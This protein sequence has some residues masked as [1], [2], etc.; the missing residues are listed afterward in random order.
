MTRDAIILIGD[1][2]A[3]TSLRLS[4]L[5]RQQRHPVHVVSSGIKALDFIESHSPGLILVAADLCDMRGFEFCRRLKLQKRGRKIPLLLVTRNKEEEAEGFRLGVSD[6]ISEP[7]RTAEVL[8]RVNAYL[9][10]RRPPIGVSTRTVPRD[11]AFPE[12]DDEAWI[13]VAMQAGRMYGFVWNVHTDEIRRTGDCSKILGIAG[14]ATRDTGTSFLRMM[15][16]KDVK[17]FEHILAILSPAFD[18]YSMQYRL[19][20]ADGE[21]VFLRESGRG[22]FDANGQLARVRGLVIDVTE[23]T[24]ALNEL[25]RSQTGILQLI[26]RLPIAVALAGSQGRI[27]YINERFEKVFGYQ[28]EEIAEPDAWWR[29]AY[30]DEK[31]RQDV[32][33]S[34]G[35]AIDAAA[36]HGEYVPPLRYRITDKS[37]KEHSVQVS[38]A[39][40]GNCKL[41]LFDDVTERAR[42]EALLRESEERFRGMAD[43]A[44]VML[45]VSGPDKRCT[46]FNK[47][48][49]T[50]TGRAMEQELGNGWVGG[51]HPEDLDRCLVTYSAAFDARE[52][53]QMEYRLRRADGEYRWILDSGSPRFSPDG[54]FAGYIGS[55]IDITESKRNQERLLVTQKLES[56]GLLAGGVVHDINNFLGCILASTDKSLSEL[57]THSRTRRSLQ[58]I[59]AIAHRALEI[60]QQV[61]IYTGQT[62]QQIERVDIA[63]LVRDMMQLLRV[64]IP[65]EADLNV[66]LP[67]SLFLSRANAP[68]LR[69]VIMNLVINAGEAIGSQNGAIT[70]T[71]RQ[72][73]ALG[74]PHDTGNH[75]VSTGEFIC[76][77]VS[78]TGKGMTDEVRR[79][80]FDPFFTTKVSG[81]GLGLA[82][83]QEIVR[84]HGGNIDVT[85]APG[86][87]TRF[88]IL[89]PC[90]A[91]PIVSPQPPKFLS[92]RVPSRPGS[93]LI[94]EDEETLRISVATMLRKRG[95]SVLEASDGNLAVEAIHERNE[96]IAVV[97]LDLTLPG[98]SS[99]EVFEELRRHRPGVKVILTSAYGLENI[100]GPLKALKSA[101]FIRKPYQFNELVTAVSQVLPAERPVAGKLHQ[102]GTAK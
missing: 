58:Q 1:R 74:Y 32:I 85:S 83:V 97:L 18:S 75:A 89:L 66:N 100:V 34:W 33:A 90:E 84:S 77:E 28:L 48:W 54:T 53:F 76:L 56:V 91:A 87:G 88:Q 20:R 21:I 5:L 6:Y 49:L 4:A 3:Q 102:T 40:I 57:G 72:D 36:L 22:Y 39:V 101:D 41:I 65:K 55:A 79:R 98:K 14:D 52:C 9:A 68:Q 31:Y 61:M 70:I 46:F 99:Q 96:D 78:D 63:R 2:D 80:I 26:D 50:F 16:P 27:E 12:Q 10:Q 51:V 44:P 69:Q 24:E 15:H 67:A 81:R 92:K 93:I 30:P 25:E 19:H 94:V 64:C 11:V 7:L 71:A 62:P 42:A 8:A 47:G 45:W 60:A 95:F 23:Q 73:T 29:R 82:A 13:R 59:E 43:T 86:K 35:R 38:A 17:Q 37:G